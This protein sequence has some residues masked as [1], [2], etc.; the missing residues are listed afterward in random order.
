M[1]KSI[2]IWGR[3]PPPTG[4]VTR[5]IVLLKEAL[6]AR[7]FTATIVD[8]GSVVR[9]ATSLLTPAVLGAELHIF[10][11]STFGSASLFGR[12]ARVL[13]GHS[14]LF[15]H[16]MQFVKEYEA[17][18][19]S[20][21]PSTARALN[22][23]DGI[24]VTNETLADLVRVVASSATP[25]V[26]SPFPT[27]PRPGAADAGLERPMAAVV[28][29]YSGLGLYGI[30][31]AIEALRRCRETGASYTLDV[32]LYGPE[33]TDKQEIREIAANISWVRVQ[34]ELRPEEMADLLSGS[35]L[36]L[37]P[38][39]RDGDSLLV[40]E[41]LAAGCRVIASDVAP[42]PEGVEVAA[43]SAQDF[44][45]AIRYG[46]QPSDGSGLGVPA[47]VKALQVIGQ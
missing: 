40:R 3:T 31:I 16:G 6:A 32:V 9:A 38:T 29:A 47:D 30:D 37:R 12:I 1:A 42:R 27:N 33:E 26:V 34:E 41:A 20:K 17:T 19:A 21:R 10:N 5:S 8:V 7:G 11:V 22:R 36:L 2:A 15:L 39:E 43:R 28:G 45:D 24:W 18:P 25:S 44:A 35:Q 46:G 4:G 23:F 13:R 14:T